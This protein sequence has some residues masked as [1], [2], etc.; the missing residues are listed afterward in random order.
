[1]A[2][3]D[4]MMAE[5]D[6]I[7]YGIEPGELHA[8]TLGTSARRV[9]RASPVR[10]YQSYI[11]K[12]DEDYAEKYQKDELKQAMLVSFALFFACVDFFLVNLLLCFR[13]QSLAKNSAKSESKVL[14]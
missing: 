9:R 4:A 14:E 11:N 1:M 8:F 13:L 7:T 6:K 2:R 12:G 5:W 3:H 10:Q